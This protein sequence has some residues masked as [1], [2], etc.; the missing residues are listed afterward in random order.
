MVA[1][2]PPYPYGF[3][4]LCAN[5]GGHAEGPAPSAE[6]PAAP[7]GLRMDVSLRSVSLRR[8]G[9]RSGW[10]MKKGGGTGFFSSRAPRR[11]WLQL[12]AGRLAY[13][14]SKEKATER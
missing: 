7:A 9:E 11:R 10:V 8:Y 14:S 1:V 3:D 4:G 5:P 12:A 2:S 6:P 13:Y